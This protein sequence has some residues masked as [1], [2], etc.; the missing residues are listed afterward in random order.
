[1][2]KKI[3]VIIPAY[4]PDETLVNLVQGLKNDYTIIVV[5][6]GSK[7]E[8][9][10]IFKKIE[11]DV[12]LKVHQYNEGKGKAIKTGIDECIKNNCDGV[13][14]VDA[15]GQHI[16]KD[17]Q[18][19]SNALEKEDC[20][21]FGIRDFNKMPIRNRM[22]NEIARKILKIRY[23]KQ[24]SDTQTGLRGI[25]KKYLKQ[26]YEIQGNRFEYETEMVK[27]ILNNNI[28]YKEIEI[29]TIYD[30]TKKSKFKVLKDSLRVLQSCIK[31]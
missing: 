9:K 5:D 30:E 29:S 28:E 22:G 13:I 23:N 24:I 17:I 20:V 31:K 19:I 25:P 2:M 15:D 7:K 21:I 27:Y 1:M 4:N 6:D 8:N 14:T 16:I 10:E 12:I 11:S 18:Q 3:N 26:F